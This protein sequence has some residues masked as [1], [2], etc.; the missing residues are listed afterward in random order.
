MAEGS[1]GQG[2]VA[3]LGGN[4]GGEDGRG[5]GIRPPERLD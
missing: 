3:T 2:S 1:E 4:L 5:V